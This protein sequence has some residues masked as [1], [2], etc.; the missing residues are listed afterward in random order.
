[1]QIKLVIRCSVVLFENFTDFVESE[2]I[3]TILATLT[4]FLRIWKFGL[5]KLFWHFKT[6]NWD[7][8]V[9]LLCHKFQKL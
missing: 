8:C 6:V 3:W 4:F 2:E 7:V 5:F 9:F 1:M